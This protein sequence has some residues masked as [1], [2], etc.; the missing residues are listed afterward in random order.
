MSTR[1]SDV[2]DNT[3]GG[4]GESHL[5]VMH[6]FCDDMNDPSAGP[7]PERPAAG[8]MVGKEC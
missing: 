3:R 6:F 4:R 2:A 1:D 7:T 8:T 5:E